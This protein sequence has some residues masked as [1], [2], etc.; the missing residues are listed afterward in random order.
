[1]STVFCIHCGKSIDEADAFCEH[2][3]QPVAEQ[4]PRTA[5]SSARQPQPEAEPHEESEKQSASNTN[6]ARTPRSFKVFVIV[7][8]IVIALLLVAGG[9]LLWHFVQSG[10]ES[11]GGN[12]GISSRQDEP[13]GGD[14]ATVSVPNLQGLT[15][16]EATTTLEEAD[17]HVGAISREYS[18]TVAE[19]SVISQ[20]P[21]PDSQLARNSNVNL[22][23][24]RGAQKTVV[25]EYEIIAE[26]LTWTDAK[27]YC[28]QKGGYLA[29]IEDENE[30][31]TVLALAKASGLKVFWL[32]GYLDES[33]G[34]FTWVNGDPMTFT[35]WAP[36]EPNND[37][38]VENRLALFDAE[39]TWGWYD[40]ENDV[41]A[42]Y[43]ADRRGFVLER[44][45]ER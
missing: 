40:T 11:S 32:G 30:Y 44:E 43:K 17:L 7:A 5:V 23:V 19:G 4:S 20:T 9:V 2:C 29:C 10:A 15:E 21:S 8:C 6:S 25:H 16:D 13:R 41:S 31:S 22:V 34:S 33:T 27:A 3:G 1:M 26:P 39:G 42:A 28:E 14:T 38:G 36:D 12:A 35:A 18:A 45:V 24:S 37:L